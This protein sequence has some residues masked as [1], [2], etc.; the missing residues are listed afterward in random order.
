MKL[1][2]F[3][4][5]K[6]G[7]LKGGTVVDASQVVRDIPHTGPHDLIAGHELTRVVERHMDAVGATRAQKQDRDEHDRQRDRAQGQQASDDQ[8]SPT[9]RQATPPMS[10]SVRAGR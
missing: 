10:R 2:F 9:D 6:L 5:F 3:D 8:R 4:D 7:V 1:L